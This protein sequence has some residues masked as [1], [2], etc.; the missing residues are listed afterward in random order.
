ML[1]KKKP[2]LQDGPAK[3]LE[4]FRQAFGELKPL[5]AE[6]QRYLDRLR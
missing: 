2:L 5:D 3:R 1:S 6:F 4:E